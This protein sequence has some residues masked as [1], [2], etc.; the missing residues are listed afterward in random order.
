MVL[1]PAV[2]APLARS[3][4]AD[5]DK[6][7]MPKALPL[8][9]AGPV[10]R[11]CT[12]DCFT[13]WLALSQR[14]ESIK[15]TL[16]AESD[17]VL[18]DQILTE[19]QYQSVRIGKKAFIVLL[20]INP[21]T[22]FPQDTF[23]DYQIGFEVDG[24]SKT[25]T[26]LLPELCY[27][28]QERPGFY[29]RSHLKKV[30]HGSC[31][32]PHSE[33]KDALAELDQQI[34]K[35]LLDEQE[36]PDLIIMSG[37]QIYADDV[38]GPTLRAIH[39]VADLLEL[40]HESW[41]GSNPSDNNSLLDD[42]CCYYKRDE[43]LPKNKANQKMLDLFF[44]GSQKPIFTARFSHN[45]LI[46]MAEMMAMYLLMW[47]PTL[48]ELV[49]IDEK[50]IPEEYI[51]TFRD[52][53]TLID[54]FVGGLQAVQRAFA[55]IPVYMIFDDH[56]VTDDWNLT[57]G[58]EE[59]AYQHPFSKRI[60]GNA[61]VAYWLCQGWGNNKTVFDELLEESREVFEEDT[62]SPEELIDKL[63]YFREWDYTVDTTPRIIVADTRTNRWRS[64]SSSNNP[65]GLMDWEAL[66]DLQQQLIHNDSVILVSAAPIFGVKLVEVIQRI[67]TFFGKPLLVDAENWMAHNGSANV[68][69]NIFMHTKTPQHFI[70]LSG[71]VHYSF[72]YDVS[73]RFRENGPD[74]TQVTASGFKNTFPEKLLNVF[75]ILDR[76]LYGRRSPLNFF[77]KRR[78]MSVRSR[79]PEGLG[80]R[81]LVN[82]S[83][84][85]VLL[86][87]KDNDVETEV[88]N[89]SGKTTRFI[90]KE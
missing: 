79:K 9:L 89:A 80:R 11:K 27:D 65:S 66:S 75:D 24:Q 20:S 37:D 17:G 12:K 49:E 3:V 21:D 46:T 4:V 28:K 47:S 26:E 23:L 33:S 2:M 15:L 54:D 35:H 6:P 14:P 53:L 60:I 85:G 25:L 51:E 59:A 30:I 36:R 64:E 5:A 52:E 61:L 90:R 1:F 88:I 56:D 29:L 72:V 13:V 39:K 57:R 73:L 71:D 10:L 76:A 58:W 74:I 32:K 44:G 19:A 86:L 41:D 82:D 68:I 43:L 34:A 22:P 50:C 81:R 78:R 84:L 7:F 42:Q 31:R 38:A 83:S 63:L 48:W 40:S 55:N 87:N 62:Y 8:I 77:T 69:L 16:S 70:I 18:F 67:F 45:H